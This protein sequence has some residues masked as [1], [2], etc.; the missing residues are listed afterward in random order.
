M[1]LLIVLREIVGYPPPGVLCLLV[2]QGKL[3]VRAPLRR[4]DL[5]RGRLRV[6]IPMLIPWRAFQERSWQS[7]RN[8]RKGVGRL[9][10]SA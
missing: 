5:V 9:S 10:E 2:D 1:T 4:H 8:A 7:R 3:I 6:E